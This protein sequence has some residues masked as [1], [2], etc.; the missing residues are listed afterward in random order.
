MEASLGGLDVPGELGD[1]FSAAN[2]IEPERVERAAERAAHGAEHQ[3]TVRE[4]DRPLDRAVAGEHPA[5][6][7][8]ISQHTD[9]A[10]ADEFVGDGHEHRGWADG[11]LLVGI[12]LQ[13]RERVGA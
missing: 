9:D 4:R 1:E 13:L 3:R 5:D 7:G 10:A 2:V 8:N 12:G 6:R 11:V